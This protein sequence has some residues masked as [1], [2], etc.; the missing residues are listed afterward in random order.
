MNTMET[1]Q[2]GRL[3]DFLVIGAMKAGTTTL[4]NHLRRHP[5]V[6]VPTY[7]EPEFFVAEKTWERGAAWYRRLFAAA[8][9]G[10]VLGEA[11]TS[12]AKCTEF[13]GVPE[14]IHSLIPHV[15][16]VYVLRHPIERIESMYEHMVLTG[17]ESRTIDQAVLQDA[18]RYVGPSLYGLNL[19]HTARSS[20]P[21]RSSFC[22][23]TSSPL[24]STRFWTA[25]QHFSRCPNPSQPRRFDTTWFRSTGGPIVG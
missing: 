11:S 21:I 12:Y 19:S 15:K 5:D 23:P 2:A 24:G 3:P 17:R 10:A 25:S 13:T 4:Y 22:S 18:A 20:L 6:F 16:L 7:K 14:R 8:P 1:S 9:D